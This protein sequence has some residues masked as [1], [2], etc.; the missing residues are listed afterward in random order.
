MSAQPQ[1][2]ADL[3]KAFTAAFTTDDIETWRSLLDS[4]G[5]WVIVATGETDIPPPPW[6]A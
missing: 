4:D 5:E 2:T 3:V 1:T 6:T